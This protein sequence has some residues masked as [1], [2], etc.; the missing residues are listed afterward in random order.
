MEP[1]WSSGGQ[2]ERAAF[3]GRLRLA[4]CNGQ[5]PSECS[6]WC[7]GSWCSKGTLNLG[8]NDNTGLTGK[9]LEIGLSSCPTFLMSDS[10]RFWGID[11]RK[12]AAN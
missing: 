4:V 5:D 11:L 10:Q 1:L 7:E 8:R 2:G 12:K 9:I 3:L 6:T